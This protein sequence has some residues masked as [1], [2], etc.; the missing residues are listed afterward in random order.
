MPSSSIACSAGDE[1]E[2]HQKWANMGHKLYPNEKL[3][4][5]NPMDL[6]R[7]A[8]SYAVMVCTVLFIHDS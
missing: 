6:G 5:Y 8:A 4:D 1:Q 3:M 7:V 2:K